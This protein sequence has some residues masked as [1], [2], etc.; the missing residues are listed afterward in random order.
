MIISSINLLMT[1]YGKLDQT[2]L[3]NLRQKLNLTK[4]INYKAGASAFWLEER[5][6]PVNTSPGKAKGDNQ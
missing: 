4:I 2:G 5:L 1:F 3:N 6:M